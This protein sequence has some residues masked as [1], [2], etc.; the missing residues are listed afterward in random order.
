M[1]KLAVVSALISKVLPFQRTEAWLRAVNR[2]KAHCSAMAGR[3]Q[4]RCRP[5]SGNVLAK[6]GKMNELCL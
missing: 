3:R 6:S 4:G 5:C 2:N 1:H